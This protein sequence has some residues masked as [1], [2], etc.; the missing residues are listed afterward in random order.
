MNI[1]IHFVCPLDDVPHFALRS[2]DTPVVDDAG[3]PL[4]K[5]SALFNGLTFACTTGVWYLP[6][7]H[8]CQRIFWL[9]HIDL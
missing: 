7:P 8:K 4:D 9:G 3:E 6:I 1:H 5:S 2:H